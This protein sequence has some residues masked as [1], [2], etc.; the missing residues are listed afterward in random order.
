MVVSASAW[1]PVPCA[2]MHRNG[3]ATEYVRSTYL[4][5]YTHKMR[6]KGRMELGV[7]SATMEP[8]DEMG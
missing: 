8:T 7:T 6:R 5:M 3:G 1:G 2:W 4:H